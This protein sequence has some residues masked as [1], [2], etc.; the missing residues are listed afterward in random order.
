MTQIDARTAQRT[1][2]PHQPLTVR[3]ALH[4]A[5]NTALTHPGANLTID[6][7][8]GPDGSPVDL[9]TLQITV[10]QITPDDWKIVTSRRSGALEIWRVR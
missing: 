6:Q 4:D 2:G 3:L 5:M 7:A 9:K 8:L 10:A 1:D